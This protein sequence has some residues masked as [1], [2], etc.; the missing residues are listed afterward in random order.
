MENNLLH[1]NPPTIL[2]DVEYIVSPS[3]TGH[4]HLSTI[5]AAAATASDAA[6]NATDVNTLIGAAVEKH[7]VN[8]SKNSTVDNM[9][10]LSNSSE[11]RTFK[12]DAEKADNGTDESTEP[13]TA[14]LT[15][16]PDGGFGWLVVLGAFMIQFCCWGFNF[17]WGVYQEYYVENDT[18]EG[19]TLSQVSWCGGLG[20]ASVFL[21]CP[22]QT[23]MVSRF[24]LRP[25][26]ATGIV[27]SG[28]GMISAS[29][30]KTGLMFGLGAGMAL[31]N[32]VAIPVQWF[33]KKRG[34]ASGITVAGSGIGG[35]TLAPLN[36]YLIS[37][38]GYKWT[39]RI[40]GITVITAVFSILF[41]IRAR[42][43]PATRR[44]PLFD[45][46]MF[47]NTG[48]T[49]LYL[50]GMLMTFGY[51]TPIFLL[52][53][54]VKDLGWDPTVGATLVSIFSG[55]NAAARIGLG[56]V[57][58]ICGPLNVLILSTIFCG[59][60]CYMFWMNTHGLAMATVFAIAYGTSAGGF[61]SLFPVVAAKVIGLETLAAT[62]GLLFSGNF[63]GNLLGT[64]LAS[65]II[66]ASGGSYTW[67]IVLAG[68]APLVGASLLL[69]IRFEDEK[70]IFVKV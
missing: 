2:E 56:F 67:A 5:G 64:P 24:G 18:F 59:L 46:A 43:P 55:V 34:L 23:Q 61:V 65:A 32:S 8:F 52:P 42:I 7:P 39:L 31:F 58:D 29:F 19:A 6:A 69:I 25:V 13:A 50:T 26:I 17:S 48:F 1:K 47:K 38:V 68:T 12:T 33:D 45:V 16:F 28:F 49:I 36:R 10:D 63:F 41:C 66:S 4:P 40:M 53:K 27:I 44:R 35:A 11:Q 21:T 14:V 3:P 15:N 30:A 37:N 60:S 62:V 70:R 51:L 57:A 22:F 9:A 54:F 20:A